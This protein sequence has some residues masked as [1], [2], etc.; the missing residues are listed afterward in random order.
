VTVTLNLRSDNLI[1]GDNEVSRK[2]DKIQNLRQAD[3][4]SPGIGLKDIRHT[5][6]F[7]FRY[8]QHFVRMTIRVQIVIIMACVIFVSFDIQKDHEGPDLG[9]W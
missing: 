1:Q 8:K 4:Y 5:N 3:L 2:L 7:K 9:T 6:K